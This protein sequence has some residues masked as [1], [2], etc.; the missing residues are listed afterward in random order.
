M[1][2]KKTMSVILSILMILSLSVTS[3]ASGMEL[4]NLEPEQNFVQPR[5]AY[6]RT[7]SASISV[8]GNKITGCTNIETDTGTTSIVRMYIEKKVG[9]KWETVGTVLDSGNFVGG[10]L[11]GLKNSRNVSSGCQYRIHSTVVVYYN[12][13]IVET[14]DR[15]SETKT[16]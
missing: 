4:E 6:I 7:F 9:T 11:D 3:L 13:R 5:Y 2:I 10:I 14:A 12:N 1:N 16:L 8:S 15:Y